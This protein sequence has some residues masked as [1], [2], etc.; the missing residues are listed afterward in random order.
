MFE[1][2]CLTT[3]YKD[4]CQQSTHRSVGWG[5]KE[6]ENKPWNTS[7]RVVGKKV[8]LA[9]AP[10]FAQPTYA[11]SP[12]VSKRGK[13]DSE[14]EFSE[15]LST[16]PQDGSTAVSRDKEA[17][18]GGGVVGCAHNQDGI[19]YGAETLFEDSRSRWTAPGI[20]T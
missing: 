11:M 8:G 16:L 13:E 15:R 4:V 18:L 2:D 12:E 1:R 20:A 19:S 14:R 17:I 9:N 10:Y 3:R 6:E 5:E 7:G